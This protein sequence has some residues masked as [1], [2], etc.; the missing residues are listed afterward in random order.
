MNIY[1]RIKWKFKEALYNFKCKCQR[2]KR[3]Y[4]YGDVWDMDQWFTSTAKPMLIHLRTHGCSYP[5]EFNSRDEWCAVLDEMIKCL[6]FMEEDKVYAFL[7]FVEYEDY[8]RMTTEDIKEAYEMRENNKN[9]FFEL[10]SKY[11]YNLWD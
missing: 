11:F 3:G 8:C 5:C 2:F 9:K 7:G 10:F 1:Y 4:A 6:E